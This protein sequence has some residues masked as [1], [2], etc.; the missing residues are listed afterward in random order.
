[1]TLLFL[2]FFN[3]LNFKNIQKYVVLENL[4][5]SSVMK[6]TIYLVSFITIIVVYC[7]TNSQNVVTYLHTPNT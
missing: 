6:L 4:E 2:V 3:Q 1:M 7:I 5:K